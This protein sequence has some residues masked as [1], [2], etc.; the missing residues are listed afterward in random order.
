MGVAYDVFG[1]G[2]TAIK[3]NLGKYMQAAPATNT[4][5]DLNPIIRTAI[6]TT[7]TWTDSNKDFVV[8]CDLS[9]SAANGECAA[10]NNKNL[11]KEVFDRTYDPSFIDGWGVRPY[12]WSLG[13]SVQQE[14]APRVSVNVGYYRNWW[15]NWYTV[16]NLANQASDWT[17]FSIKAPV[18]SRLPGNGGQVINGLYDL[19]LNKVGQVNEWAT[20]SNN[21]ANRS[22]TGRAS[23]L[24]SWRG[25]GAGSRC[26]AARA[27]DANSRT[28]AR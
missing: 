23:T 7:R 22:R 8:N 9:N 1:N 21:Y 14:V 19:N 15:G 16:D 10:M 12:S 28:R 13:L 3:F 11:G 4:D 5:L 20:N 27:P 17:Q 6:S 2:K 25:C 24:A 18:D 26:R